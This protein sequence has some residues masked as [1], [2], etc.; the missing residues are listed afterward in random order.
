VRIAHCSRRTAIA[1]RQARHFQIDRAGVGKFAR[2]GNLVPAKA[3]R[4]H[5]DGEEPV[6]GAPA[7]D[8]P[9]RGFEFQRAAAGFG[10]DQSGDA[11]RMPFAGARLRAVIVVDADRRIDR[12]VVAPRRIRAPSAVERLLPRARARF[13]RGNLALH[14]KT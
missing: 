14:S 13:G 8:Y 11:Q 9:G 7:R 10:A 5:V 3:R 1:G 2:Q 12:S 4:A 6:A